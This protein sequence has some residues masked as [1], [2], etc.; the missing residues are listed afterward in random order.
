[1]VTIME[2]INLAKNYRVNTLQSIFSPGDSNGV[3]MLQINVRGINQISKLDS[4]CV[5]LQSLPVNVDVLIIGETWIKNDRCKYYNIPGFKS[6]Y[7]SRNKSSGGL[8]VF[9]RNELNFEVK[10]NLAED[11]LHH[12]EL[13]IT[14]ARITVH[15]IY[16][17]PGYELEKFLSL[18]ENIVSS[19]D[20]NTP[21]FILGDMNLAIND[22]ESRGVQK[23]LQLLE[24]YNM[25]V[26][27][28]AQ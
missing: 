27:V 5:F 1:M 8:A 14:T 6:T 22:A 3:N 2:S 12:I 9:V 25:V 15:G 17:P 11:G 28:H 23:Y 18:V 19:S 16:R 7:S 24:S 4:L 13:S 20:P 21:C 26:I 10:S